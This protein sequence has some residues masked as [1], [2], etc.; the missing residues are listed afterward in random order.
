MFLVIGDRLADDLIQRREPDLA[1]IVEGMAR[2]EQDGRRLVGA[3]RPDVGLGVVV[4][5]HRPHHGVVQL[6]DRDIA[7]RGKMVG[8]AAGAVGRLEDGVGEVL[9]EYEIAPR[10]GDKAALAL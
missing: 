5:L 8:A 9:D 3:E 10:L 6:L 4:E 2:I 7:A 1:E